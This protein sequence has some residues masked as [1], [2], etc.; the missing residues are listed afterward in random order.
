MALSLY[1]REYG[2][3]GPALILLHGLFGSSANWGSI[4]RALAGRFRVVVPDL[5]N[6]GR[7][8]HAAPM[9]YASM[10][11]DLRGLI[12]RLGLQRPLVV[13]HSMGGKVAMRLALESPEQVAGIGV[14]DIAPVDYRHDFSA[15]FD[16]FEAVDLASLA[17]RAEAD[18]RVA[19]HVPDGAV[20]AFLLQ[21][22]V[23]EADGWR[24]RL[25]LPLLR[26]SM[27]AITGFDVPAGA[28]FDGPV[29]FIYGTRSHYVQEAY[30]PRI[31]DLFPQAVFCAVE[32]AG[33][34][35]YAERR[36]A[37]M[38]CLDKL[39]SAVGAEVAD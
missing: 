11:E 23:H 12:D 25:N 31:L 18:R 37:F 33:H 27:A 16:G 28:P 24:W 21:N 29:H 32:G 22:L 19:A 17:D 13:G 15:V 39:L 3:T 34:W 20:R 8:P 5:R 2:E 1:F 9:D 30:R 10:A 26:E 14:V 6:H 7:S 35:V 4:A 38:H 36:E